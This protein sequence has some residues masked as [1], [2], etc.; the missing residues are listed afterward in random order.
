MSQPYLGEIRIF[1]CNFA[2]QGWAFCNGQLLAIRQNTSLFSLIGTYF[3]GDGTTTFAL[4]N[5]QGAAAMNCGNGPGLTSRVIGEMVGEPTVGLLNSEMPAHSHSLS[6][7]TPGSGAGSVEAVNTP[8]AQASLGI[9]NPGNCY[10]T[11]APNTQFAPQAIS[12]AGGSQPHMN[13]QPYAA[14]NYC[15]AMQG[16]FPSR[17]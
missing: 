6:G 3:G 5:Y 16:V 15:I 4:P 8:T 2:P 7:A 14:L 13:M 10:S 9:S 17:N 12:L 1:A 11:D